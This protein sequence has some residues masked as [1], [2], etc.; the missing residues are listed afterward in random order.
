MPPLPRAQGGARRDPRRLLH[1]PR[2]HDVTR[3][4]GRRAILR[5]DVRGAG[6]RVARGERLAAREYVDGRADLPHLTGRECPILASNAPLFAPGFCA[7][8]RFWSWVHARF[9]VRKS[10]VGWAWQALDVPLQM[11]GPH[12]AAIDH[13]GLGVEDL[14]SAAESLRAKGAQV[15]T[16]GPRIGFVTCPDGVRCELVEVGVAGLHEQ[17]LQ[18]GVAQLGQL[19]PK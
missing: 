17:Q 16:F 3:R 13:I 2:P 18:E 19:P 11:R 8:R 14:A 6:H 12:S 10:D 7:G 5:A 1:D 15:A 9:E 4:H